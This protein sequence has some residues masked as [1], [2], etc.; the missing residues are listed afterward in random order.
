MFFKFSDTAYGQIRRIFNDEELAEELR[1]ENFDLGIVEAFHFSIL[2]MFK[3]WGIKAYVTGFS[4]SL[5]DTMYKYFGMPFPA[6][7]IP[8]HM[9][10]FSDK[11]TYKERF[12]NLFAHYIGET[13]Y[14][15]LNPKTALQKE[16][17]KKYG[18]GFY[19]SYNAIGDSSFIVINSNPFLDIPGP[20]TPKMVEV[21]GIGI[22]DTKPLNEYWN[23]ILSLRNKTIL[24]SFGTFTKATYMPEDL[25]NGL[26]EAIRKLNDIT[27]I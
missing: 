16:F 1:K 18:V 3:V 8:N 6:S 19:N 12:Q 14:Y 24:V 22:K 2:G 27:F 7:F 10:P 13:V 25:K 9:S 23:K 20:K 21:S 4:M 17:D 15:I 26:L 5:E 11:M